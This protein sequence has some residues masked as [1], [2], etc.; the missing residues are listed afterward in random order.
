MHIFNLLVFVDASE[1]GAYPQTRDHCGLGL[2][3][4]NISGRFHHHPSWVFACRVLRT[5]ESGGHDSRTHSL[6]FETVCFSTPTA[7]EV[8]SSKSSLEACLLDL[9]KV[10]ADYT[11][12]VRMIAS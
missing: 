4:P 9:R 5:L 3:N 2:S 7:F 11:C 8:F 12:S 1:T 6:V 10:A